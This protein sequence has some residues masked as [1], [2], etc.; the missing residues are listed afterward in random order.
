ME[1]MIKKYFICL[2]SLCVMV[3]TLSGCGKELTDDQMRE[4]SENRRAYT[5]YNELVRTLT[6]EDLPV[7]DFVYGKG[8]EDVSIIRKTLAE[9]KMFYDY[10]R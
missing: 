5:Y 6:S 2:I 9:E 10:L 1:N 3:T 4:A 7:G 8:N